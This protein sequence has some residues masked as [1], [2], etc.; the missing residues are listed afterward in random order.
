MR[1]KTIFAVVAL[2]VFV[3]SLGMSQYLVK[4]SFNYPKGASIDTLM[5]GAGN[6]WAG[7]WY[8]VIAS[9]KN[10]MLAA[11][12]GMPYDALA[13]AVPYAGKCMVSRPD[14]T[15]TELRYARKLAQTWPNDSGKVYWV[16]FLMDVKNATDNSTWLGVKFFSGDNG[17]LCMLGK[18]HGLD[19][20][21]CGSGWHGG[22]GNEVSTT[23]WTV[24]PVWLVGK[25]VMRGAAS[26]TNDTVY[27]WINPDPTA[28]APT[29]KKA[30]AY[31]AF[32][33]TNGFNTMR[34]EYGG[35]IGKGLNWSVDEI[36][37]GTSWS[38]V[39]SGAVQYAARESFEYA[40][41]ASIDTL[42][43]K[44]GDGWGGPW[45]KIVASEKNAMVAADTG[46][47]YDAL[48]YAVPSVG[49]CLVS[50]PDTTGTELR[51]GRKL[52]TSWPNDSGKIYWI[53]MLMDVKNATDNSTWLGVKF[54]NGDNGEL[55]MLGK[56]HGL[57]KY[58]CGGG[59]H[60]G[61]GNEVSTTPWTVGPVWL[62]GQAVMKG[63][64]SATNDTIYMWINPDPTSTYLNPKKADAYSAFKFPA[65]FN[66]MRIE[67]GGT[68]GKGL[69]WSLDE[70]RMGTTFADV[71]SLYGSV[72]TGVTN[73]PAARPYEYLLHQN[74]PNPFNP[75]SIISY[76]LAKSGMVRLTVYDLLGREI[77]TLVNGVQTAGEHQVTFSGQGLTSGVYF[78]KL[79]AAGS[80]MTK[81]MVLMK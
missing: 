44:A 76:S 79:E 63:A 19:K 20:Y 14:T 8:K 9:Q 6:G 12:T 43:G 5:G 30:D 47:P 18:G 33:F 62:V 67:Y 58:T 27:M 26:S 64:S 22:T 77:T 13:Y 25:I 24:G 7:P 10:A 56:G 39:S 4:E 23:P 81:K 36:R 46:M 53:S 70:I 49:R 59:W 41:K 37:L 74:Y 78:Y 66:T 71:S 32:K 65:N 40:K 60:G 42:M 17:E 15:G 68:I 21:T 38:D 55:C 31:S 50:A 28:A 1:I 3:V 75:S 72:V 34:I 2:V 57:D 51:Y 16:S 48:A 61:T 73:G 11:D 45:Y 52:A 80:S 54:Y 35:T 29:P 69:N